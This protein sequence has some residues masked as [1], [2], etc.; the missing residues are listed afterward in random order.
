MLGVASL[1]V[2]ETRAG[3]EEIAEC[4]AVV[5]F[6]DRARA[7]KSG[8]ALDATNA[9]AVAQ[10]CR[11]LDGIALAIE[12]AAARVAVLTPAEIAQRLDSRFRLLAGGQRTTVER[13]Q[14]LRAAIDW[15]YELLDEAEQLLLARLSVFAGGFALVAAE[16]VTP[17]SPIQADDVF[18]L[19]ATLVARSLVAAE[20]EGPEAR[21]RLLETIRQ[22]AQEHLDA[23]G[24]GDRLRSAHADYFA[25]FSET[26]VPSFV[27]ATGVEWERRFTAEYDN[28][29]AALTWATETRDVDLALRLLG[30]W[31][32]PF[33]L[34]TD[35]GLL[36]TIIWSCDTVL[37][38]PEAAEHPR[39]PA[40]LGVAGT[41]AWSHG[42]QDLAQRR[43][44]EALAAEQRLGTE[45]NPVIWTMFAN[46]ALARGDANLAVEHAQHAIA[47]CRTRSD[48]IRLASALANSALMRT[49]AGETAVA[50]RDAEEAVG[51][52]RRLEN[53][54][55]ALGALG[56]AAFALATTEPARALAIVRE[57]VVVMGPTELSMIW[58]IAGDL[59]AR[60]NE[61]SEAFEYFAKSLDTTL[62]LGARLPLG[63]I[64]ARIAT[65]LADTDPETAALLQ[66]AGQAITPDFRHA[67]HH[68]A[69]H[70]QAVTTIDDALGAERRNELEALGAAMTD[71]EIVDYANA[72]IARQLAE[73]PT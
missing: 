6:V 29:R 70:E 1:E 17:G 19:L 16:A 13:H 61:R 22:Y 27:S 23:S 37:A 18:E 33:L 64:V 10:V 5:L 66:G 56:L 15:S 68:L 38:M 54:H 60:N 73:Q 11:R 8:F 65:M 7:V 43:C 46:I 14:T 42:A 72:A 49:M 3:L 31:D 24:E 51:L 58:G 20:T 36:S 47:L 35:T 25:A 44:E 59:A 12:L 2:P 63:A 67:A 9:A 62:W 50:V 71:T 40:A 21:Y 52:I 41:I 55:A 26:A 28:I 45:P 57:A 32:L 4:D 69:A 34:A 30:M 39:Y 53:P 48:S